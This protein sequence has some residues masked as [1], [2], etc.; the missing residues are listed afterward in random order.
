[1]K[2][3]VKF[4]AREQVRL[5]DEAESLKQKIRQARDTLKTCLYELGH[6]T[7]D[8]AARAF[9]R[10]EADYG[11]VVE[12]MTRTG[13]ECQQLERANASLRTRLRQREREQ[14]LAEQ[15]V[16]TVAGRRLRKA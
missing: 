5:K 8:A 12:V 10:A 11:R 6:G 7:I 9:N 14:R 2:E 16:S 15:S 3:E 1:M 4:L 13:H